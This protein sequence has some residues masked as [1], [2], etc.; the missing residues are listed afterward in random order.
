MTN[1]SEISRFAPGD[2]VEIDTRRGRAYV[3]V[4]HDHPSYPQVVRG[5]AAPTGRDVTDPAS[6]RGGATLFTGM[7]PL[8]EVLHTLDWPAKIIDRGATDSAP[9]PDFRMAV[10]DRR[11]T[12]L[13]WWVW[14][15]SGLRMQDDAPGLEALPMREVLSADRFRTLVQRQTDAA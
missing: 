7:V 6:L 9:F 3:E 8:G 5:L 12:V 2:L 10:R 14:D 13:Y 15:G 4:T 1:I 11:G